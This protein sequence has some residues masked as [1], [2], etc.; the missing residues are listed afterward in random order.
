[1]NKKRKV[2]EK[3]SSL[4]GI[5]ELGAYFLRERAGSEKG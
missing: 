2:P 5:K 1:M 4:A 3:S